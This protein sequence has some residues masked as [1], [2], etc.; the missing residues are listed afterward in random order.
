MSSAQLERYL[1]KLPKTSDF[2]KGGRCYWITGLAGAGKT[3]VGMEI[4]KALRDEH[5][6]CVFLDG[7]ILRAAVESFR[8][9]Y[10]LEERRKLAEFYGRLCLIL[11]SQGMNVVCC[12]ISLFD[13]VHSWNRENIP[14]YVEV[15]LRAPMEVIQS[16]KAE[17]YAQ[18]R[19]PGGSAQ[20]AGAGQAVDEPRCPDITIDNDG[21]VSPKD[22][23]GAII[24][25][26]PP[27]SFT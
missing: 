8:I 18:A 21:T 19:V 13:N 7:D 20:V 14:G 11:R 16:R 22:L 5:M 25:K 15:Y 4:W 2:Q 3:T 12:T 27:K 24:H 1:E 9:G 26:F 17:V 10:E 6:E 23:A